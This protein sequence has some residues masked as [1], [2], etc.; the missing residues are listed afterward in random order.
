MPMNLDALS[1]DGEGRLAR[2]I[3]QYLSRHPEAKDTREGISTWWLQGQQIE[4]TVHELSKA[5]DFLVA[6]DFIVE[7]RGPDLRPYYKINQQQLEGVARF[8]GESEP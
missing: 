6:R 2:A 7:S 8:L 5:L 4:Q 1:S 3:L